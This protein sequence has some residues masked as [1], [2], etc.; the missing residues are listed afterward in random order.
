MTNAA[1]DAV[2][3]SVSRSFYLTLRVL[4]AVLRRPVGLA[5]LLART[6]DTVADSASAAGTQR[7][8]LLRQFGQALH[9]LAHVPDFSAI[10]GGIPDLSERQLLSHSQV[11][12]GF[13]HQ[14][15]PA[16]REEILRVLDEILRG[17]TLDIERF[18]SESAGPARCL[19]N[20]DEL[21]AYTY[22]V[23]GCVGEFWTRICARH[24][25]N[26]S[27]RD[28]EETIQLGIAFGKGLQLVNV[29]R[30]MPAD[31]ANG[32]CYLPADE[33]REAAGALDCDPASLPGS[34]PDLV[35]P[36]MARWLAR[37]RAHLDAGFRYIECVRPWRVRLACF[38]PWAIGV[39][40]LTLLERT[41]PLETSIRVKVPRSEVRRLLLW[42]LLAAASNQILRRWSPERST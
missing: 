37:A 26:Y 27:R 4:P 10:L 29:L 30:D 34:R 12:V 31:L 22:S 28:L 38:L 8:A 20:A 2:L 40:T 7:L 23:A 33:L 17:Q 39:K 35:R 21:D 25:R 3:A 14:T 1:F 42:G 6:S 41:P 11:L 15:E 32:R 19:A 9:G 18:G 36:V 5:Y 24:L 13:L 16:D